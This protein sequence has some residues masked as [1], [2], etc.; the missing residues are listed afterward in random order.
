ML[1]PQMVII[2]S[3]RFN[4]NEMNIHEIHECVRTNNLT[5]EEKL[6]AVNTF[7]ILIRYVDENPSEELQ[8][9]AVKNTP[10]SY[11][12][13]NNPSPSVRQYL[14]DDIYNYIQGIV[15]PFV[16]NLSEMTYH[17]KYLADNNETELLTAVLTQNGLLIKYI[18]SP[19]SEMI[20]AAVKQERLALHF[21]H[22]FPE[23]CRLELIEMNPY[24]IQFINNP[25]EELQLEAVKED[26][27][28]IQ[29]INNPSEAVQLEAVKEN[30]YAIQY[31]NNPCKSVVN[32][33]ESINK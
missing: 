13:I 26:G 5:D 7:G 32:Y 9:V 10:I 23:D 20:L 30:E 31:I 14:I 17:V 3:K 18:Y 12:Y 28:V 15:H 1:L 25:S 11:L 27:F 24:Y 19:T 6:E 2:M 29:Y 16:E 21:I 22:T 33:I 8:M 4:F